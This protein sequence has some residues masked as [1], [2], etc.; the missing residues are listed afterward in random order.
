MRRYLL[1]ILTLFF[2]HTSMNAIVIWDNDVQGSFVDGLFPMEDHLDEWIQI[3]ESGNTLKL[4]GTVTTD[5]LMHLAS[6]LS[7]G[8]LDNLDLSEA[9]LD[10]TAVPRNMFY[11]T[12]DANQLGVAYRTVIFPASVT[13]VSDNAFRGSPIETLTFNGNLQSIGNMGFYG[14][15]KLRELWLMSPDQIS[16][17][18]LGGLWNYQFSTTAP[19]YVMAGSPI[20]GNLTFA[21]TNYTVKIAG[22]QNMTVVEV[23]PDAFSY[24][25]ISY[26]IGEDDYVQM[27]FSS[28]VVTLAEGTVI[29]VKLD[30]LEYSEI[31]NVRLSGSPLVYQNKIVRFTVGIDRLYLDLD[32][33]FYRTLSL[34]QPSNGVIQASWLNTV[35]SENNIYKV[36][37]N[38]TVIIEYLP[39][40]GYYCSSMTP[41]LKPWGDP[42]NQ[43][44]YVEMSDSRNL[45]AVF[46]KKEAFLNGKSFTNSPGSI[47]YLVEKFVFS[48]AWDAQDFVN[49][50]TTFSTRT[51]LKS[52]EFDDNCFLINGANLSM[53]F[54]NS[55]NLESVIVSDKAYSKNLELYRTFR[56]CTSLK[57]LDLRNLNVAHVSGVLWGCTNAKYLLINTKD[58]RTYSN[59]NDFTDVTSNLL[60]YGNSSVPSHWVGMNFINGDIASDITLTAGEPFYCPEAFTASNITYKRSFTK[61]SGVNELAGYETIVLPFTPTTIETA[62]G[63]S[64]YT[65]NDY[66]GAT[67]EVPF[68]LYNLSGGQNVSAS[69]MT[70]NEGYLICFPNNTEAYDDKYNVNGEVTF[71]ASNATVAASENMPITVGPQFR[72]QGT[73]EKLVKSE[74]LY[75]MHADGAYFENNYSDVLPFEARALPFETTDESTN[76]DSNPQAARRLYIA[77]VPAGLD[78]FMK[79]GNSNSDINIYVRYDEIVIESVKEMTIGIYNL[80][81]TLVKSVE[82]TEGE[83]VVSGL[84]KG[85]YII[86]GKK[87]II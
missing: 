70:A 8:L 62:D 21:N 55:R 73:Y 15:V 33:Y 19:I 45:T 23:S 54:Y 25:I 87:V 74:T 26:K 67:N 44:F 24:A 48:G 65:W 51:N 18:S 78:D 79:K 40:P 42:E 29:E 77:G 82:V 43:E 27:D 85:V 2:V 9:V 6:N 39:E 75:A 38:E 47:D 71:S 60:I 66:T 13:S 80:S 63:R 61:K 81:G 46:S 83:N 37:V 11:K 64:L 1:F 72:L 69:T 50:G 35:V 49:L 86:F 76:P 84:D 16:N 68:W 3:A 30:P 34:N 56:D 31:S 53:T 7:A 32:A 12:P 36:P 10:F 17:V 52:I 59:A 58:L 20:A 28:N 5:Q 22:A 4:K 57:G 41:E 14:C